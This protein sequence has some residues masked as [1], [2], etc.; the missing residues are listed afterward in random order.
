[1]DSFT[2]LRPD[3][4]VRNLFFIC[5]LLKLYDLEYCISQSLQV[6]CESLL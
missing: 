3:S 2:S 6:Y 1:M 4:D 5:K